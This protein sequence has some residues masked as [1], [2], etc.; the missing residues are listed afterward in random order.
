MEYQSSSHTEKEESKDNVHSIWRAVGCFLAVIIPV[1]GFT[2]SLVLIDLNRQ[3]HY[4]TIPRDIVAPGSDPYL[5]I[6]IGLTIL[7]SLILYFLFMLVTFIF[8]SVLGPKKYGPTD[9]PQQRFRGKNYK[10]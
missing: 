3:N 10:R 2:G 4:L 9:V 5:Y 6:K 8:N 7:I 1:I